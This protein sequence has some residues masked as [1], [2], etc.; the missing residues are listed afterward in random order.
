MQIAI[1]PCPNDTFTFHALL[2]GLVSSSLAFDPVYADI[3]QLNQWALEGRYPLVKL[4]FGVLGK[5]LDEYILL[6]AGAA[7]G[8]GVGPKL[9][10]KSAFPLEELSSKRVA[11]P[12]KDTTAHRLLSLL[13][14]QPK[15]KVFCVY[16][17][18][19]DM[20]GSGEVDAGLIIHETRFTFVDRGLVE[21][22]DVGVLFEN[23]YDC[24]VPLGG[25][26]AKRSLGSNVLNQL[27]QGIQQS[28][29][30]AWEHPRASEDFVLKHS[31]EKDPAVVQQHI[32]L[33]VN[34]ESTSLSNQAIAA[35]DT[36][37]KLDH[38]SSAPQWLH[39]EASHAR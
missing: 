10:A 9:I 15:E 35:I 1:S 33:Y 26:A 37:L 12:G 6:N 17:D 16:S 21:L 22:A 23:A 3:Q 7:M 4:S 24:P 18:I 38:H 14:P 30:F 32:D 8:R 36:L 20:I 11:I 34:E 27:T 39:K 5:V 28:L 31:Q 2:H 19:V 29:A 25:I 13:L